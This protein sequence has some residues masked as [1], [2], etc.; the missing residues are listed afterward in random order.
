MIL[1]VGATGTLGRK[2]ARN[3]LAAGDEVRAM[4]RSIARGDDLKALGARPVR[5]DLRDPE[6]LE[7]ALR[8]VHTVV[9]A[10]HSMLGRGT[11]ASELIDDAAHRML[12]DAAR[13]A[14]VQHFVYTSVAGASLAH[15]IDFWRSKA[16]IERYLAES[17]LSHTIV[18]PTAFMEVYAY[19][20]IGKAILAGKRV[21]LFGRGRNPRNFVAAED[22]AKVVVGALRIPSLRGETI[23]IGGPENLTAHQV[24]ETFERVT[25]RKAKVSH[26]PLVAIRAMSRVMQPIHPGISRVMKAGVL[27]ETTDQTFDPSVLRSRIPITLTSLEDWVR[28]RV[29]S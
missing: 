27:N 29:S 21:V 18:R 15:P 3:L 13:A 24:V 5:A 25:G 9:T 2:V 26:V 28:S 6:S 7:F 19:Q 17:G 23:E 16:R 10:A 1:V 8:G 4:T 20:L 11:E 14:G 22:V 12:I